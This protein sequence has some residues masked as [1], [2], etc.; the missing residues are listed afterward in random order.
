M[1]DKDFLDQLQAGRDAVRKM[2]RSL[3]RMAMPEEQRKALL[4]G[5][6]HITMPGDQLQTMVDLMDAFGP[7]LAQVEA[8]RDE[9]AEQR[10]QVDAMSER[11]AHM[12][13]AAERLT[14]AAE[15]LVAFQGP[16]VK[17]AEVVTGQ[18]ATRPDSQTDPDTHGDSG[19]TT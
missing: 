10:A 13:A 5:M 1:A 8:L 11:L 18:K 4:E 12:E 14:S 17:M 6:S 9:L 7:P 3:M 19:A 16:F 15:Q 2:Q